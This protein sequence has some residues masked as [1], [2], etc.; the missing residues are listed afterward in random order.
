MKRLIKEHRANLPIRMLNLE[1]RKSPCK[2]M[3]RERRKPVKKTLKKPK[4]TKRRKKKK[5]K[6]KMLL[7]LK[8]WMSLKKKCKRRPIKQLRN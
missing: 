4:L 5:F 8:S 2:T 1:S 7:E 6:L 3:L